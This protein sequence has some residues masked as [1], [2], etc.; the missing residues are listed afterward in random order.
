[1]E[2]R[3][4]KAGF[5]LIEVLVSLALLGTVIFIV[6]GFILPLRLTRSSQIESNAVTYARSYIELVKVRWLNR[7]AFVNAT[8]PTVGTGA[9]SEIKLPEGWNLN[10]EL[11]EPG[12]SLTVLSA[13][14]LRPVI[15]TVKPSS[16]QKTWVKLSTFIAR[17]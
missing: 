5:T 1:V 2:S 10:V 12:A 3:K 7:D 15:V 17:P 9:A 6:S 8:L 14:T 4:I 11:R 16:D 13:D